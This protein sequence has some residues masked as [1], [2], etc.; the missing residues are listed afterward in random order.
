V[1]G[2][3]T[4]NS[5]LRIIFRTVVTVM[6]CGGLCSSPGI[7]ADVPVTMETIYSG[8]EPGNAVWVAGKSMLTTSGREDTSFLKIGA[9][10]EFKKLFLVWSGELLQQPK[11]PHRITWI[12]PKGTEHQVTADYSAHKRSYGTI[13]S[14]TA[15][16]T[17]HYTG[18][19]RYG[20]SGLK[21][22]PVQKDARYSRY[23]VAGYALVAIYT[24]P[25]IQENT[26]IQLRTGLL[27]LPPGEMYALKLLEPGKPT[28]PQQVVVIGGHGQKG[29]AA[30]NLLN[31]ICISGKEDWDGSAGIYWDVDLFD[32]H[33]I[34]T[35]V[36]KNGLT[37]TYDSLLQWIYPVAT[38]LVY[39]E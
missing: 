7:G 33:A 28:Q 37:L 24:D 16:I 30:A 11:P 1:I 8:A 31:S 4:Q 38:V 18:K 39:Q 23:S 6:V 19:G 3:F 10:G 26:H 22:D 35:D 5:M 34:P 25:K 32:L 13:Y 17:A 27:V 12:T 36:A 2:I 14:C 15:D 21:S 20:V 9:F 29:N